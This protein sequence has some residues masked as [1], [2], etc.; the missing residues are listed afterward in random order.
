MQSDTPTYFQAKRKTFF[1][2]VPVCSMSHSNTLVCCRSAKHIGATQIVN[3]ASFQLYS[4]SQYQ[5]LF[6]P[7]KWVIL[8][9]DLEKKNSGICCTNFFCESISENIANIANLQETTQRHRG[10][11]AI[12]CLSCPGLYWFRDFLSK[13]SA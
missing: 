5:I 9:L 10:L 2:C 8:I 3:K 6:W 12:V 13:H 1:A 4:G 7:N 11:Y